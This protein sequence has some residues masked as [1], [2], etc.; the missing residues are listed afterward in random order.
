MY[1]G[2]KRYGEAEALYRRALAIREK[3]LGP[4]HLDVASTLKKLAQLYSDEGR[5]DLVETPYLRTLSIREKT[6]APDHP[7]VLSALD[8]L[9]SLYHIQGRYHELGSAI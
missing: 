3:V 9:A 8:D 6:L 7:D 2:L 5:F 4:D 1:R